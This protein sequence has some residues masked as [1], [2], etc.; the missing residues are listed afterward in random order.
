MPVTT[1]KI[2]GRWRVVEADGS[3]ICKNN[4]GTSVDGKGH[5]TEE[6]AQQQAR[7]INASL[8]KEGKI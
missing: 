4:S 1:A 8:Q 5:A 2:N 6:A 3:T 7:A